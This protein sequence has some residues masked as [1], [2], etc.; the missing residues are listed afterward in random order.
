VN[1]AGVPLAFIGF[2]LVRWRLRRALRQNQK[3]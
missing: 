3:L 1:I 2:G